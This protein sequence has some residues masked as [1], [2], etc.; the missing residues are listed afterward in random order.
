MLVLAALAP[1]SHM[2]Q[3][4]CGSCAIYAWPFDTSLRLA[5]LWLTP[6]PHSLM[7]LPDHQHP[8]DLVGWWYQLDLDIAVGCS[9]SVYIYLPLNSP[10]PASAVK[11]G[12]DHRLWYSGPGL[13]LGRAI[14]ILLWNQMPLQYLASYS[15]TTDGVVPRTT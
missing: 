5:S 10:L 14:R 13:T 9:I 6:I 11:T 12:K 7:Y 15:Y 8:V 2:N 1:L 4:C 3:F